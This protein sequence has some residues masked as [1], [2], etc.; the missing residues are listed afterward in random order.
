MTV[1]DL[2]RDALLAA[3]DP[4][5]QHGPVPVIFATEAALYLLDNWLE[6]ARRAGLK[7]TLLIA[8]DDAV[9][10]HP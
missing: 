4:A 2:S 5:H 6:H 1:P 3:A 8:L 7:N 10:A 9:A